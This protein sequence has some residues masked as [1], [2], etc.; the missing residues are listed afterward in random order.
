MAALCNEECPRLLA[1]P[2]VCRASADLD[3]LDL[4]SLFKT[5]EVA[6]DRLGETFLRPDRPLA[7]SR[8]ACWRILALALPAFGAG[9]FTPALRAFD[10]P[11]AMACCGD[12]APCFP[13]RTWCISS[14]TNSPACVDA[15][16]PCSLSRSALSTVSGSGMIV[17]LSRGRGA[18]F[19]RN[20]GTS[21]PASRQIAVS[22][23]FFNEEKLQASPR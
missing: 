12:L 21:G 2:R 11:M 13:S 4:L 14:R 3:A 16:F 1:A 18:F 10:N 20:A 8:F 17:S 6:R 23:C 19:Q 9:S 15:D 5:P 22:Q 7:K